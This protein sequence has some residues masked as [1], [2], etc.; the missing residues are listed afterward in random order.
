MELL[1]AK[2]TTNYNYLLTHGKKIEKL[3]A[4]YDTRKS[5]YGKAKIY[6]LD[7]IMYLVSYETIVAKIH[8]NY[9]QIFGYYSQTTW[10]HINE[11]L[12][13]NGFNKMKKSQLKLENEIHGMIIERGV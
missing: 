6:T 11:F 2:S 3:T 13:Q 7:G 8:G 1:K 10:R 9:A 5:F 4:R 12:Y